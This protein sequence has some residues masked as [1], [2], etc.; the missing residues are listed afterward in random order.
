MRANP[1][2]VS[3]FYLFCSKLV[4]ELIVLLTCNSMNTVATRNYELSSDAFYIC[5]VIR[6]FNFLNFTL[7]YDVILVI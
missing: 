6:L 7:I 1:T 3:C 4:C 5:D 2:N